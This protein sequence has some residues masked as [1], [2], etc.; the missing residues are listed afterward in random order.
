M[1]LMIQDPLFAAQNSP[2]LAVATPNSAFRPEKVSYYRYTVA[3]RL[4][5][6]SP[7][8]LATLGLFAGFVTWRVLRQCCRCWC[9]WCCVTP[10]QVGQAPVRL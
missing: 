6:F 9:Q 7:P 4:Y 8:L 10:T 3:P 2:K 5:Y 1:Q